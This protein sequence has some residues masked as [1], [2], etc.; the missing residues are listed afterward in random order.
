MT[1]SKRV[2]IV[3]TKLH[4]AGWSKLMTVTYDFQ[5]RDGHWQRQAR[6]IFDC[7]HGAAILLYDL[8]RRT[9]ILTRQFRCAQFLDDCNQ[10]LIEA[11]AGML[12]GALPEDRIIAEAEEETGYR[13]RRV[14]K[15][16]EAYMSPGAVTQKISCFVGEYTPQDRVSE[17]G[18]LIEEGEDI[19]VLELDFD[20]A[21]TMMGDGQIR[22]GKTIMLLQYAA[23]NLFKAA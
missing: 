3:D 11:P 10:M 17:G 12:D 16:L 4:H 20:V 6:E 15:V 18:G 2:S 8:Q 23:L 21:M 9:V 14:E 7:G 5:R 1:L 22:D 19:E 13:V